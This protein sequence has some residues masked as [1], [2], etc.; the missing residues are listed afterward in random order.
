MAEYAAHLST[1][2]IAQYFSGAPATRNDMISALRGTPD[3]DA[4]ATRITVCQINQLFQYFDDAVLAAKSV[5]LTAKRGDTSCDLEWE[6]GLGDVN[7]WIVSTR[8]HGRTFEIYGGVE[9]NTLKKI[10][11]GTA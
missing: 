7:H 5:L 1:E 4:I 11:W 3:F 2:Y 10:V 8:N 6:D 9:W